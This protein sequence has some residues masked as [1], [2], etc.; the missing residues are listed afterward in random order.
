MNCN[1]Q[2]T[3]AKKADHHKKIGNIQNWFYDVFSDFHTE[4]I[5]LIH[6]CELDPFRGEEI[7]ENSTNNGY[8]QKN[9]TDVL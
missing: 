6:Q 5:S 3:P 4:E 1:M 9:R 8:G 7:I 2:Y